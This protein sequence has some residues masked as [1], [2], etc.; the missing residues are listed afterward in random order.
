MEKE[1]NNKEEFI[2]L[3]D[4]KEIDQ[5]RIQEYPK[6]I[7][8]KRDDDFQGSEEEKKKL[9]EEEEKKRSKKKNNSKTKV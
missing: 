9:Q 8:R 5:N 1:E 3:S 4:L 7:Q 6:M 2:I